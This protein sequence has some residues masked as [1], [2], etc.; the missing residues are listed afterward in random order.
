MISPKA[1][2]PVLITEQI[3]DCKAFFVTLF[4]FQLVFDSDWY[5]HLVHTS[6]AQLGFLI[7]NHPSQPPGLLSGFSGSGLVYSFEV[8]NADDAF[9]DLKNSDV[10]I[11]SN[12]K[13]EEWGQRHFMIAGPAGIIVDIIQNVDPALNAT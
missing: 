7:P 9:K 10:E 13:T 8:E 6:G 5:I 12:P 1:Y 3:E 11:V 4:G 2:F